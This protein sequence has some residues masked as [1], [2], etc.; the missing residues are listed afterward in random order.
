MQFGRCEV[1]KTNYKRDEDDDVRVIERD[2]DARSMKIRGAAWLI[3]MAI[4]VTAALWYVTAGAQT[5]TAP[6]PVT[7]FDW[8][9][10]DAS[11]VKLSDHTSYAQALVDC[12][13]NRSGDR[14]QGGTYKLPVRTFPN[15]A[16]TLS[17]T[18]VAAIVSGQAYSFTPTAADEDGDALTFSIANT[19]SWAGFEPTTGKLWG[20]PAPDKV[21]I[22]SSIKI[23]VSDGTASASTSAFSITVTAPP[24][25][26]LTDRK[27]V[28]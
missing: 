1:I 9:C 10:Q 5:I 23:T 3:C 25:Q 7:S 14:I 17:G 4:V 22:Y 27:S 6:T 16:P 2:F 8:Q 26:P 12:W 20:V 28:V 15:R 24:T 18:P 21:G 11:G 13:N 19:P